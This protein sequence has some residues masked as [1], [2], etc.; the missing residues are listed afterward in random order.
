[1]IECWSVGWALLIWCL[2]IWAPSKTSTLHLL[3]ICRMTEM[4]IIMNF[5]QMYPL[6]SNCTVV[7]W[8]RE[9]IGFDDTKVNSL[10]TLDIIYY[11]PAAV[12]QA[13]GSCLPWCPPW[14]LNAIKMMNDDLQYCSFVHSYRRR[15]VT[16]PWQSAVLTSLSM[17]DDEAVTDTDGRDFGFLVFGMDAVELCKWLQE[18]YGIEF[19]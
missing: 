5:I 10:M 11:E 3:L 14:I 19:S 9:K 18:F 6:S 17:D 4:H 8:N 16:N 15:F 13:S 2:M 12:I 7:L 1:M